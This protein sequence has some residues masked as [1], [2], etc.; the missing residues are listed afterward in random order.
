MSTSTTIAVAPDPADYLIAG[1]HLKLQRLFTGVKVKRLAGHRRT[2]QDG[3]RGPCEWIGLTF[4][5]PEPVLLRFGLLR[6]DLLAKV[7]RSGTKYFR[8][9][10]AT[11]PTSMKRGKTG[12]SV[13]FSWHLALGEHD[14]DLKDAP[15][16]IRGSVRNSV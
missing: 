4:F 15:I 14:C 9:R 11:D 5:G 13:N 8:N 16:W 3:T 10:K 7:P 1:L 6:S 12:T 2:S